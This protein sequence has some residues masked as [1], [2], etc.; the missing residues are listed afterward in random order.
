[1]KTVSVVVAH[2]SVASPAFSMP[3]TPTSLVIPHDFLSQ[4]IE[5]RTC[6]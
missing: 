1:M 5:E 4:I 3:L 2:D 6:H